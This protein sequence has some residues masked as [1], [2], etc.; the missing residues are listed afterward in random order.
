MTAITARMR[1][2]GTYGHTARIRIKKKQK[3][4]P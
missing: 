2:D 1:R 4:S 3:A